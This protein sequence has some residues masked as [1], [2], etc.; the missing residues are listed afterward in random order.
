[1]KL[2]TAGF[3]VLLT[4]ANITYATESGETFQQKP[5]QEKKDSTRK[6]VFL[7]I[8]YSAPKKG[9]KGVLVRKITPESPAEKAGIKENDLITKI[10]NRQINGIG[11]LQVFMQETKVGQEITLTILRDGKGKNIKVVLSERPSSPEDLIPQAYSKYKEGKYEEAAKLYEKITE[12][13]IVSNAVFYNTAC[14][15]ALTGNKGKALNYLEKAIEYGYHESEEMLKD[16][17]LNSLHNTTGW[18][19][20]IKDCKTLEEKTE[21][22]FKNA[23]IYKPGREWQY[24]GYFLDNKSDTIDFQVVGLKVTGKDFLGQQIEIMWNYYEKASGANSLV[25]TKGERTGV[26]ND[27]QTVWIHPPRM[28]DFSFTELTPFPHVRKPLTEGNEWK[29]MLNIGKGWGE[30]ENLTVKESY[31]AIGQKDVSTLMKKLPNCWQ[32]DA[33]GESEAGTYK[34]TYY[35]HPQYGFVRWEYTKPDSTKVILDLEKVSG[36]ENE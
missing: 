28:S 15:F 12:G 2:L 3:I 10:N 22:L 30:W 11:D 33:T 36:F 9:E 1:M 27:S 34:I 24:K 6:P 17:D 32:V 29:S 7:G 25:I 18:E 13:G 19:K 35:F 26:I 16:K 31:K 5:T 8:G 14:C 4:Y 23:D 21:E 20:I